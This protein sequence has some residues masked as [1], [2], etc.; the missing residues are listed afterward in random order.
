MKEKLVTGVLNRNSSVRD[1]HLR[2]NYG[3]YSQYTEELTPAIGE[4]YNID[5]Y[6]P[7][8]DITNGQ[9]LLDYTHNNREPYGTSITNRYFRDREKEII[10]YDDL[11][12]DQ[13]QAWGGKYLDY[14]TYLD[15][16]LGED[17]YSRHVRY[18][19]DFLS[20]QYMEN[21][22][23]QTEVGVIR[24][25]NVPIARQGIITTNP[26]NLKGLDTPLGTITNY[27]YS[28]LL[29]NGAIFNSDRKSETKYLTPSLVNQYGNNLANVTELGDILRVGTNDQR[30]RDDFGNDVHIIHSFKDAV[31]DLNL[32]YL[33]NLVSEAKSYLS[34]NNE[35][36]S[37]YELG[38]D[39]YITYI[40]GTGNL[41]KTEF[42]APS[43][44]KSNYESRFDRTYDIYNEND[45]AEGG[46]DNTPDNEDE[47]AWEHYEGIDGDENKKSL[48]SRTAELFNE[49][50]INTLIGR[51][52]TSVDGGIPTEQEFIDTAKSKYGNSH[53]RNLLTR[54]AQESEVADA[55]DTNG[56][57]N[58]Y[59]RTW[60]YHHQ[61]N[62]VKK[63]IR[64]F[65]TTDDNGQETAMEIADVQKISGIYRTRGKYA[66]DKDGKSGERDL[67]GPRYLG[68][69]TVL[70]KNG[71]VNICPS[72][73]TDPNK[74]DGVSIHKCMFSIENLA[75]KDV[76]KFTKENY[77]SKEQTG[78]NGGRI[79]WFPPYDLSFQESVNVDWNPNTFI[80]RGEKVYTYTNTER[81]GTLSFTLLIDHPSI[82]NSFAKLDDGDL[83]SDIDSDILRYFAGCEIPNIKEPKEPETPITPH[84][85][86][87]T[88]TNIDGSF[89]FY[90]FFP[91]NYSGMVTTKDPNEGTVKD[92]DEDWWKYILFGTNTI[93]SES[94]S[95]FWVGYEVT[96]NQGIT[97]KYTDESVQT[98]IKNN[99][100][101]V[102]N[103]WWNTP[104]FNCI[105][106]TDS[107]NEN[108]AKD[109]KKGDVV[110]KQE[111][112]W[113]FKY[114]VDKDL[115]QKLGRYLANP[116]PTNPSFAD[117]MSYQLNTLLDTENHQKDAGFTFGEV[118]SALIEADKLHQ[119]N[120]EEM[121]EFLKSHGCNDNRIQGL[122]NIF[123]ANGLKITKINIK[124][125]ADQNDKANANML[126]KRRA[127]S[128]KRLLTN[129]TDLGIDNN[130]TEFTCSG[131]K[132][133]ELPKEMAYDKKNKLNRYAFVTIY[134]TLPGTRE[135]WSNVSDQA[136]T[137]PEMTAEEEQKDQE[138]FDTWY[139]QML[140]HTSIMREYEDIF[141]NAEFE[142]TYETFKNEIKDWCVN[143]DISYDVNDYPNDSDWV[144][145]INDLIKQY[146]YH[147][148]VPAI[149][150]Q[151]P[152]QLS[153]D[154]SSQFI[155]QLN[156]HKPFDYNKAIQSEISSLE[157]DRDKAKKQSDKYN[158][159][160]N[161]AVEKRDELVD[162]KEENDY[163]GKIATCDIEINRLNEEIEVVKQQISDLEYRLNHWDTSWGDRTRTKN[164]LAE[165]KRELSNLESDKNKEIS[166]KRN[167]TEKLE[168]LNREIEE[169]NNLVQEYSDLQYNS[170]QEAREKA[171]E[172]REL[173]NSM[174]QGL[175]LGLDRVLSE[176]YFQKRSERVGDEE[177]LKS[178]DGGES[179]GKSTDYNYIPYNEDPQHEAVSP[180]LF[181]IGIQTNWGVF[182]FKNYNDNRAFIKE[183]GSAKMSYNH[184]LREYLIIKL[185]DQL[186]NDKGAVEF[187]VD[188]LNEND[189]DYAN[190]K[191]L[192]FYR[193]LL[194]GDKCDK[195]DGWYISVSD[196]ASTTEISN[197]CR[198]GGLTKG[199]ISYYDSWMYII[200]SVRNGQ[201]SINYQPFVDAVNEVSDAIETY[202][203]TP[204]SSEFTKMM[205]VL[206]KHTDSVLN[207]CETNIDDISNEM[208]DYAN[209]AYS[210]AE[211]AARED[212]EAKEAQR[213]QKQ[214]KEECDTL[215]NMGN[216]LEGMRDQYLYALFVG[217]KEGKVR[218]ETEAE[219]FQKLDIEHPLIFKSIKD[220]FK[221]FNPAFHSMS[222]EGFNARLNFLHQCTRQ[223]HTY[224]SGYNGIL[225]AHNLAF[226]RMPV[227]VLRIGDFIN[228]RIII[229][230]VNINYDNNGGMQ[231][232]L[233][234]EGIGVQP[235]FAKV[236]LGITILGGQSLAGP[237]SRL[238]NAV[239]FDYYAN[240]GVYDNRADRYRVNQDGTVV[241]DNV[242]TISETD[243]NAEDYT[244]YRTDESISANN[245]KSYID[246]I[247][248]KKAQYDYA[249]N[250]NNGYKASG[251]G[252]NCE[253]K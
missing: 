1:E 15:E 128:I 153:Q 224:E 194:G 111:G 253:Q 39:G 196:T 195:E 218:Y 121:V 176:V 17:I 65:I 190:L 79:M 66:P 213:I 70:N 97:K 35:G 228:T 101:G 245:N 3:K 105:G 64:P 4:V 50:K 57:D 172:I 74:K 40:E 135:T 125:S 147:H 149:N 198:N 46:Y 75:W 177:L 132:A 5:F 250:V 174:N 126:A 78:P 159:K 191:D 49:H 71:F 226:G 63:L 186:F 27:M 68:D 67:V 85:T 59:C 127:Y 123:A 109:P 12:P 169:A 118:I 185:I 38:K 99:W 242:F 18:I 9:S 36:F 227:C 241:F 205:R 114:R 25:I 33:L 143:N 138:M 207:Y 16:V 96:P 51:F 233:N 188:F 150:I 164:Q 86:G 81:T 156:N 140:A 55:D 231:W 41:D 211:K 193:Y 246:N 131:K 102:S 108:D 53:G 148:F 24:N 10:G 151:Y 62:Q 94:G 243:L 13:I 167:Y 113:C 221:Y 230:N 6:R 202:R 122:K 179:D 28:T 141:Q 134:Y 32:K 189:I 116:S 182:P 80:G 45:N 7:L 98:E 225:T 248:E 117:G 43:N 37:G 184:L 201:T 42:V 54:K 146:G 244:L 112:K 160:Y 14:I 137:E 162:K 247:K 31:G 197:I 161:K 219:Y 87:E 175:Y 239:S 89:S 192:L 107:Y 120:G 210:N 223:G 84:E 133:N 215:E 199:Y 178:F 20:G 216:S 235:M 76:P 155:G 72:E 158:E 34:E 88:V 119:N 187:A 173:T 124:G 251:R 229:N 11:T 154:F 90:V 77:I 115:R 212:A 252:K 48:L 93:L 8:Y 110:K 19:N 69:N 44:F 237:I 166:K 130:E 73:D 217:S 236:N 232:D 152:D 142:Q 58:P 82:V 139:E 200:N 26:N 183:T 181:E 103:C 104:G 106:S 22:L 129:Y 208:V 157:K 238:Q 240:T 171:H 52:H 170:T 23:R 100:I 234:P 165:K 204:T 220:K 61:Y 180:N 214:F 163:E 83:S 203:T 222:P 2:R 206:K 92:Y 209:N 95:N 136:T 30:L 144:T 249:K 47:A 21:A 168:D 145:V 56:Y 29:Y 91:N 60:T